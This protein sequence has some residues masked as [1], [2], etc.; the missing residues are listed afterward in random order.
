MKNSFYRF[1]SVLLLFFLAQL[2]KAQNKS[3]KPSIFALVVGI[4][5]YK[6]PG[7]PDLEFA[8]FDAKAFAK[9]LKT[10][11][12]GSL[13]DENLVLLTGKSATRAEIMLQLENHILRAG[14]EDL[15]IFYFSGHGKNGAMENSGFLMPY[16][17]INEKEVATALDMQQISSMI[18]KSKAKVKLSYIDACHAG[19][20]VSKGAKG[21]AADN[22]EI[23]KAYYELLTNSISGSMVFMS[24]TAREQSLELP[25]KKQ[26]LFTYCL[27]EGLSG[28]ADK[29]DPDVAGYNDSV[30]TAGELSFY[31]INEMRKLSKGKQNPTVNLQSM[32]DFPLSILNPKV[33]LYKMMSAAKLKEPSNKPTEKA[34]PTA[35]D[36]Q[37]GEF[38]LSPVLA[39]LNGNC[40][41]MLTINNTSKTRLE[42]VSI[43]QKSQRM[44]N[45]YRTN[46][47]INPKSR[48][49]TP[50]LAVVPVSV[51][52]LADVCIGAQ[53]DYML[54]F[55]WDEMG[56]S[57]SGNISVQVKAGYNKVIT[58]NAA[59]LNIK[60]EPMDGYAEN[61]PIP[62]VPQEVKLSATN[63]SMI[64]VD[65]KNTI[66]VSKTYPDGRIACL[67][68]GRN[69]MFSIGYKVPLIDPAGRKFNL[70]YKGLVDDFYIFS[71]VY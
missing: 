70:F 48:M 25:D 50:R 35:A 20:F 47:T 12:A 30:V 6:D 67:V 46:M 24:S 4:A 15:F 60:N 33:S 61:N 57:R 27:L 56:I 9:F 68:N 39:V 29:T 17:A 37:D 10:P 40:A 2:S 3:V 5:D 8:E 31:L 53:S 52:S 41:G 55:R 18:D 13:P 71:K 26:G 22:A 14:P 62:S 1:L 69:V 45:S 49:E 34:E 54:Y 44:R 51:G 65:V 36:K 21:T 11:S 23:Q 28:L 38:K 7:V 64:Q 63:R 19:R 59:S 58:V 42:L 16:D 32:E 66:A 43:I